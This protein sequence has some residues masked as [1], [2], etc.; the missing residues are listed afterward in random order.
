MC[1][2]T[3]SLPPPKAVFKHRANYK[4]P[5]WLQKESV[6]TKGLDLLCQ[7]ATAVA[8]AG[9]AIAT[10]LPSQ[11]DDRVW[12][13]K[14]LRHH[15]PDVVAVETKEPWSLPSPLTPDQC[16]RII[17]AVFRGIDVSLLRRNVAAMMGKQKRT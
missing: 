6:H 9:D 17:D 15:V 10:N 8:P 12:D 13:L 5:L 1:R 7:V 4:K 16:A 14:S 11:D 2:Q 3:S